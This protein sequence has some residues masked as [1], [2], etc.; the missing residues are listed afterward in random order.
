MT[1][2]W[3]YSKDGAQ[4]GPVGESEI[5]RLIQDG[6]LDPGT[7]VLMDG[8][9]D[10]RP[11]RDHSCFQVEIYPKKKRA[12]HEINP[13]IPKLTSPKPTSPKSISGNTTK[14]YGHGPTQP[15]LTGNKMKYANLLQTP[16]VFRDGDYAVAIQPA[17][18]NWPDRCVKCNAPAHGFRLRKTLYWQPNW[19]YLTLLCNII[20]LII[21]VLCTRKS[22]KVAYG[23]CPKHRR[24]RTIGIVTAWGGLAAGIVLF[25]S[26]IDSSYE[27]FSIIGC[28]GG[29]VAMIVG[30]ILSHGLR[31][32][33]IEDD[34]ALIKV[35]RP[36]LESLP[37]SPNGPTSSS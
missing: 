14:T 17:C 32:K 24:Q 37:F 2:N 19:V 10:W 9:D 18:L 1:H 21:V 23:L 3:Y 7:P 36:F 13:V 26:F 33:K 11:A 4:Y 35:G 12:P 20:I 5:I 30:V 28:G 6:D 15:I 31:A 29:I 16:E 25:F 22:I 8:K 27:A 34:H